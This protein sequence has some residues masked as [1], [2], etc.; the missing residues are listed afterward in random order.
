M[1]IDLLIKLNSMKIFPEPIAILIA[2][3]CQMIIVFHKNY[4]E[5]ASEIRGKNH[6]LEKQGYVHAQYVINQHQLEKKSI[7]RMKNHL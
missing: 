5:L 4:S 2:Y 7:T 1:F 3:V 6:I